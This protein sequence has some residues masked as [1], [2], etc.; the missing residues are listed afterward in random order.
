MRAI[1]NRNIL[2]AKFKTANFTDKWL[3]S[4]GRPEL[5][6][7]WIIFGGSGSGKTT[8]TLQLCKYLTRFGRVAYNSLEQ[9]FSLSLQNAWRRV[10]MQEAGSRII[11]LQKEQ[12]PVLRERLFKRKS[13]DIVVIDSVRYLMGFKLS[14]YMA[15]KEDFPNKLFL[16]TSHE[17]NREPAGAVAQQIRY[18]ADVKIRVEG[19]KAFITSRFENP[20]KEEG[21]QDFIIWEKGANEYWL[22]KI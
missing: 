19:Y 17:K 13:P 1:S 12:L 2:D 4:F 11:L 16:F 21:G 5:S 10:D 15:L 8:F 9:G 14:D 18:D 20:E 3:A 6:G 22:D 7:A